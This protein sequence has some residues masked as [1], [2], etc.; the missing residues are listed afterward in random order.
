SVQCVRAHWGW[1]SNTIGTMDSGA[2]QHGD[3]WPGNILV[4]ED[5]V[6]I[7]DWEL[8]G[9]CN[10]A[11]FDLFSLVLGIAIEAARSDLPDI[12]PADVQATFLGRGEAG[13]AI[14]RVMKEHRPTCSR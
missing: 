1:L 6:G 9:T 8:C 4:S 11:G 13:E 7:V 12:K 3:L 2:L 14:H 10:I 5:R